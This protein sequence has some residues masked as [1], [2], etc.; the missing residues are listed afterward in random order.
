MVDLGFGANGP[1]L[2]YATYVEY[3]RELKAKNVLWF[4]Y[5]GNDLRNLRNEINSDILLN[6]INKNFVQNLKNKQTKI[7]VYL[8]II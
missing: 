8:Q 5:E 7:D 3:G 4:Y 6:Y 2:E 1:L